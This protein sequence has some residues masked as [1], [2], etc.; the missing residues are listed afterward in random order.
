MSK[1]KKL[2]VSLNE[3]D[4]EDHNYTDHEVS[5]ARSQLLSVVKSATNI[6]K[7]LK[8]RN[9]DEGLEGWVASKLT[10]AED[11]LQAVSDHMNGQALEEGKPIKLRGFGPDH[12]KASG[13]SLKKIAGMKE[14]ELDE[15][16]KVMPPMDPKY[17]ERKGLEGPF[18][19]LSGKVVYYDPKEGSYYDPDTD[20]YMTYDEFQNYDN[21][22]SGMKDEQD[23]VKEAGLRPGFA[24][25]LRNAELNKDKGPA[26][27]GKTTGPDDYDFLKNKNKKKKT[28]EASWTKDVGRD[29]DGLVKTA[30]NIEGV[31]ANADGNTVTI[32]GPKNLISRA[33][34]GMRYTWN[35][36]KYFSE[37]VNE[38]IPK[39]T[40]YGVAVD[41]KYIAK[42]NKANMRRLAKN[43]EGGQLMNSPSKKVGDSVG[44]A[45][46]EEKTRLDPKCWD[47]K[48]IG[49]P[50]T[51]MKNG[52]RV[53]N[54]VPK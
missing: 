12:K 22:Y 3:N 8:D 1:W 49:D 9:E 4:S 11:Y 39:D 6:A 31:S 51:K 30:N 46:E 26:P 5:M 14:A 35:F 32:T 40:S 41:G 29:A 24:K 33:L 48:K 54:C 34:L 28:N 53:N 52:V 43:T 37:E 36:S 21:D 38:G 45:V 15:G 42:G 44:K 13:S 2:M 19:T 17:V 50:K 18:S 23:E 16:Y 47:N 20:M 27:V 10:M 25:E 7:N